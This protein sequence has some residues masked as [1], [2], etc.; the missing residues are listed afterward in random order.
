MT[1]Y[2]PV[3]VTRAGVDMVGSLVSV[4]GLATDTFPP[5]NDNYLRV[6]NGNAGAC[7]VAV[8][9]T[10]SIAGPS[11]TFLAPLVLGISVPATTG[12]RMFGPFPA[13]AFADGTDGQVHVTYGVSTT[14]QAAVYNTSAQ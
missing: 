7:S 2:V 10:A 1:A 13:S 5:S 8:V 3:G 4:G 6:K 14:V 11:G 12:D 9:N